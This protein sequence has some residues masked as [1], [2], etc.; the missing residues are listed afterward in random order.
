MYFFW[1]SRRY[2]RCFY[3]FLPYSASVF[4]CYVNVTSERRLGKDVPSFHGEGRP[5]GASLTLDFP[6]TEVRLSP[7]A[8]YCW[9][10]NFSYSKR[11]R[12]WKCINVIQT[13]CPSPDRHC[14][15]FCGPCNK[16]GQHLT[17]PGI[18]CLFLPG[19]LALCPKWARQ[20]NGNCQ[21]LSFCWN[22]SLKYWIM[23]PTVW[24]R[25]FD[26]RYKKPYGGDLSNAASAMFGHDY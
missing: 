10:S 13:M 26:T 12:H 22:T 19:P 1:C 3:Y 5:L 17:K 4:F 21:R 24:N 9:G 8:S 20:I 11:Y 25:N 14:S 2:G 6:N 16:S 18:L 15:K 23:P 7:T